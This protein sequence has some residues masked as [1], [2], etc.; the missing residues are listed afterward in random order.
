[1]VLVVARVGYVTLSLA[2]RPRHPSW[3][4]NSTLPSSDNHLGRTFRPMRPHLRIPNTLFRRAVAGRQQPGEAA[5]L[6]PQDHSLF[7]RR[8]LQNTTGGKN[9]IQAAR[10]GRNHLA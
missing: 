2:T 7:Y 4:I 10:G 1:M 3:A 6:E 8:R 5:A 9:R